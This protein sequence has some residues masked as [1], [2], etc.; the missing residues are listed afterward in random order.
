MQMSVSS[1]LRPSA[2]GENQTR[3][4]EL[5]VNIPVGPILDAMKAS[6]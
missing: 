4:Q 5:W 2:G 6:F 1:I 3:R